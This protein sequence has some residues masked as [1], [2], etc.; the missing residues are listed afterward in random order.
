VRLIVPIV[1]RMIYA[2]TVAPPTTPEKIDSTYGGEKIAA[3]DILK[4]SKPGTA[5]GLCVAASNDP[6]P[7]RMPIT[8]EAVVRMQTPFKNP[9]KW[10]GP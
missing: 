7:Y 4:V 9:G 1:N 3:T 10:V 6:Y 5:T 8:S 2:F